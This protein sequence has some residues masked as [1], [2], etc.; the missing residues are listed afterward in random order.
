MTSPLNLAT[1][2]LDPEQL[3]ALETERDTVVLAGPGSGKTAVLVL[4]VA[5]LLADLPSA[6][7][8]AC[9]TFGRDA[10]GEFTSRLREL[11]VQPG[12]RL[13]LGTVHSFSLKAI[14]RPYADLVDRP[15]LKSPRVLAEH[16]SVGILQE[17]LDRAGVNEEPKR[18][19]LILKRLRQARAV[20]RP[21]D[22]FAS[23]DITV[24]DEYEQ[25]LRDRG[26]L[27]FDGM[28]FE[29][30]RILRQHEWIRRLISARYAWIVVDEYQDLAAPLHNLISLLHQAGSR[31]FVVGDPDQSI[32]AFT[33][34]DPSNLQSMAA[35]PG[36][37]VIR[38]PFNYRAGTR[39]I[40]A[41][42]AA[43]AQPRD[44][45]PDPRRTD[46]GEV[47]FREV[48][49]GFSGQAE[50][51]AE[52]VVPA[53]VAAGFPLEEIGILVR[54]R[55]PLLDALEQELTERRYQVFSERGDRWP[56]TPFVRWLQSAADYALTSES[57]RGAPNFGIL[58][59]QLDGYRTI[60]ALRARDFVGEASALWLALRPATAGAPLLPWIQEFAEAVRL[61]HLLESSPEFA[62][63]LEE[64]D[65][66]LVVLSSAG[67]EPT[68][69]EFALRARAQDR[70][71]LT[72]YHGSKGREFDA[73]ILPGLQDTLLPRANWDR[74]Q[75]RYTW[76]ETSVAEDR[77]LFYVGLTRARRAAFLIWSPTWVNDYGY[78]Q[79]DGRSRFVAEV[80]ARLDV[81][82]SP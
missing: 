78:Q 29:A 15:D 17:A 8:V 37:A 41:S 55:G 66:L 42:Q 11:G 54:Q 45:R 21:L 50:D 52:R 65:G 22:G 7:G 19:E 56:H 9:I 10:A 63:E 80:E 23:M 70:L 30:L 28:A 2:R 39:L 71:V 73:V 48:Q 14:L 35:D 79:S 69:G 72:T 67:E 16:A 38:L 77:R 1:Q 46:P 49:G 12:R 57:Q 25:I 31:L 40:A 34:G 5:N 51:V 53:L 18:Y 62:T 27:D 47:Y 3:A 61:R 6:R 75:R 24:A 60:P 36:F 20:E 81:F 82:P 32:F 44:Y 58:K 76:R 4:K 64:F 33:G 68:I 26:G 13:F 43:L 59:R 74:S